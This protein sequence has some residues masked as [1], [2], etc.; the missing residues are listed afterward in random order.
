MVLTKNVYEFPFEK[1]YFTKAVSDPRA[2]F[3]P[4]EHAIDFPLKENTPI[5][6]PLDGVVVDVKMDSKE[7]GPDPKYNDLKYINYITLEHSK[8]E[9]SQ[10]AHLK[11]N[12]AYVVVGDTVRTGQKIAL[13][14]NTGPSSG[15][16]LHFQVFK[17]NNLGTKV[18]ALEINFKES[19]E[20]D[21]SVGPPD[22]GNE[23]LLEEIERTRKEFESSSK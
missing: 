10:Y 13:S 17:L 2:H 1:K 21:R 4:A 8:G 5:L 14:G 16:H 12:N 18:E 22:K 11:Y 15:P 20:V 7:G 9:F 23:K 3:G 19:L 6:A